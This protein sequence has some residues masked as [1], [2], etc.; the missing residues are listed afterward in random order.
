MS[1]VLQGVV[2][3]A[4]VA[5]CLL[6]SAWRLASLKLRLRSLDALEHLPR[7]LKGTWVATLRQRTFAQLAGGCSGCAAGGG[8]TPG[9]AA[10]PTRTPGAPR[11]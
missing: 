1:L 4:V 7:A 10:R 8:L 5:A 6:Y 2:V 11:R 9:A 3:S